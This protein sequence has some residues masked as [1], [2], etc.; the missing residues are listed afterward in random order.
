MTVFVI[1]GASLAGAKAA[2]TLRSEGFDG[3]IML[4]GEETDRPYERPPLSKEYMVGKAPRDKAF[5]HDGNWY[6]EHDVELLLGVS[7]TALDPIAHSVTLDG[8]EQMHY[9][10][11]LLATGSRPRR[12]DLPGADLSGVRYLRTLPDADLILEGLRPGAHVVVIGGG[13]IGLETVAAAVSHG[14]TVTLI[15]QDTLPLR[16]VLGDE[17]ASIYAKLHRSHGVDFRPSSGV[18]D[19]VGSV[20]SVTGVTLSDGSVVPADMAIV[21][22]GVVPNVELAAAAGIAVDNGIVTDAA[23]RTSAA[24][25]YACG[26]VSSFMS[27]LVG[28]HLR[29]EHWANAL[30]GGPAA[31]RSML[32]QDVSYDR[33]PYFYSDQYDLGM[34]YSGYVEPGG[35]DQVVFRGETEMVDGNAP[36]FLAF[37]IRDGRMLAGMNCNIWDV[38]DDIQKL[39]SAGYSGKS[40]DLAKLANPDVPLSDLIG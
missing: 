40:V 28:K 4:I 31:A 8:F 22:V 15:E 10:K 3:R 20:G 16:R 29:I 11:L 34:E 18:S 27:P 37:W 21:G 24:D 30:N 9:D 2:E 38:Q 35:Y 5:V 25:V 36:S 19:F 14:S 33:V 39:V 13:W 7:V 17:V 12:L 32:G 23:L 26:D 1:V 6:A